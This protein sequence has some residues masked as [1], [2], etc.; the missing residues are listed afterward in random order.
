MKCPY[1]K[2]TYHHPSDYMQVAYDEEGFA[3]C[4]KKEC[5]YYDEGLCSRVY[6]EGRAK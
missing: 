4:Y 1:R 3:E 5:P 6:K 2:V